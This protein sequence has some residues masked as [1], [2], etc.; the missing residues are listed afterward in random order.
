MALAADH[1]G[2]LHC[3]VPAAVAC[4]LLLLL[5]SIRLRVFLLVSCRG[6]LHVTVAE[7]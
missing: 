2:Y 1:C 3:G 4:E 6:G 5:L 7:A